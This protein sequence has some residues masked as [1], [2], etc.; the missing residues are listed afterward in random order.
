MTVN[1]YSA[2]IG[3]NVNG[4]NSD[5]S[6][7]NA[8]SKIFTCGDIP[9]YTSPTD[10]HEYRLTDVIDFRPFVQDNTHDGTTAT[11]F[12][13]ANNTD[14]VANSSLLLPDSATTTTLDY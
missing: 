3:A 13:L 10:G 9:K 7:L 11:D 6:R 1:S 12:H 14:A 5:N 4:R 2:Q 8:N